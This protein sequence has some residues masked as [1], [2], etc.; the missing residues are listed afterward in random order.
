MR[1]QQSIEIKPKQSLREQEFYQNSNIE[2]I[3]S[4]NP[5]MATTSAIMN[6][7]TFM[8][9]LDAAELDT[10]E[11][12]DA[13]LEQYYQL[14]QELPVETE[15]VAI[16]FEN[17]LMHM[18]L[19]R[20]DAASQSYE[21]FGENTYNFD[22]KKPIGKGATAEVF[23]ATGEN[24]VSLILKRMYRKPDAKHLLRSSDFPQL[25]KREMQRL[26]YVYGCEGVNQLHAASVYD[27]EGN[28]TESYDDSEASDFYLVLSDMGQS[29]HHILKDEIAQNPD[30]KPADIPI[31]DDARLVEEDSMNETVLAPG[32]AEYTQKKLNLEQAIQRAQQSIDRLKADGVD[33]QVHTDALQSLKQELHDVESKILEISK[34]TVIESPESPISSNIVRESASESDI[35][36]QHELSVLSEILAR[37]GIQKYI[38][39][40]SS[41]TEGPLAGLISLREAGLVHGDLDRLNMG[42]LGVYDLGSATF[43]G[44]PEKYTRIAGK[45]INMDMCRRLR[46]S[47]E[48]ADPVIMRGME[49]FQEFFTTDARQDTLATSRVFFD[50]FRIAGINLPPIH[51]NYFIDSKNI[52]KEIFD[53]PVDEKNFMFYNAIFRG[54]IGK[55]SHVGKRII[56]ES[57]VR[58]NSIGDPSNGLAGLFRRAGQLRT[59]QIE[60]G[61]V[62]E[63]FRGERPQIEEVALDFT[64][65]QQQLTPE[66]LYSLRKGMR[67]LQT[68]SSRKKIAHI[69]LELWKKDKQALQE[70]VDLRSDRLFPSTLEQ[71]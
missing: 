30:W 64:D 70:M 68:K 1:D 16:D 55:I 25:M 8:G 62:N 15:R 57:F 60:A 3:S 28:P 66:M 20:Y 17:G 31:K 53:G 38:E 69:F 37:G 12:R 63:I 56:P 61:E 59:D 48:N 33:T 46:V 45:I 22:P 32:L 7:D 4:P 14:E 6:M 71:Y 26:Q 44:R 54:I 41:T 18:R 5:D 43:T 24:G 36:K 42:E 52:G 34:S 2:R 23:R 29:L 27:N 10:M 67:P 50:A 11:P 13:L 58:A 65:L 51:L 40:L 9:D 47:E 21:D 49:N 39:T 19:L 35:K